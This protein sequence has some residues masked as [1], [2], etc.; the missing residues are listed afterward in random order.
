MSQY[1]T[2]VQ[3]LLAFSKCPDGPALADA[4]LSALLLGTDLVQYDRSI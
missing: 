2:R 4:L 1:V 3:M